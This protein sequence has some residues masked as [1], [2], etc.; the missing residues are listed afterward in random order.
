[1][2]S[3]QADRRPGSA[4]LDGPGPPPP[5]HSPCSDGRSLKVT[6]PVRNPRRCSERRSATGVRADRRS[7]AMRADGAHRLATFTRPPIG[8]ELAVRVTGQ[9]GAGAGRS[10]PPASPP[11]PTRGRSSGTRRKRRH[12]RTLERTAKAVRI[13]A[14]EVRALVVDLGPSEGCPVRAN[15]TPRCSGQSCRRSFVV[16]I[17]VAYER[18][19]AEISGHFRCGSE[20]AVIDRT[21]RNCNLDLNKVAP[22]RSDLPCEPQQRRGHRA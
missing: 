16:R 12:G 22:D 18:W 3:A 6:T 4:S 21:C 9:G 11:A 14:S 19:R 8:S 15:R 2:G 7:P 17:K 1:M 5:H 10:R 20:E 13:G